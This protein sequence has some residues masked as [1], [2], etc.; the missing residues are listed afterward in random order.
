MNGLVEF[1]KARLDEDEQAAR[2]AEPLFQAEREAAAG[3]SLICGDY[4]DE[5]SPHIYR[6]DSSR[7]LAEVEAKRRI[8]AECRGVTAS[9]DIALGDCVLAFLALPYAS[10]PDYLEEWRP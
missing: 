8:I 7:V 9:L 1:L 6:W 10:H 5:L 2:R 3:P 4:Y